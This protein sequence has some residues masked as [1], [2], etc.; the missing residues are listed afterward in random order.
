MKGS[1]YSIHI[2]RTG[3]YSEYANAD[4]FPCLLA[5]NLLSP[6]R[7]RAW[8]WSP[9]GPTR[10]QVPRHDTAAAALIPN[11]HSLVLADESKTGGSHRQ[12]IIRSTNQEPRTLAD[13]IPGQ[14]QSTSYQYGKA[15]LLPRPGH[16]LV[17]CRTAASSTPF[18]RFSAIAKSKPA[19]LQP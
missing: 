10:A 17:P 4:A 3:Y 14:Q 6:C 8:L 12:L 9:R 15:C 1:H 16:T 11:I 19:I 7:R 2:Y 18:S 5:H 13:A